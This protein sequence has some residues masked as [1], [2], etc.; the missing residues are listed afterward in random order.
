MFEHL[1]CNRSSVLER[2]RR[3]H[4]LCFWQPTCWKRLAVTRSPQIAVQFHFESRVCLV[5]HALCAC[6]YFT[7]CVSVAK[8]RNR[9]PDRD[10]ISHLKR[11]QKAAG[12]PLPAVSWLDSER[13]LRIQYGSPISRNCSL[14][15]IHGSRSIR[16][17]VLGLAES[18]P[19][20]RAC[21]HDSQVQPDPEAERTLLLMKT[22]P[23]NHQNTVTALKPDPLSMDGM[24]IV[25][26]AS[27]ARSRQ[28]PG[29]NAC[30]QS[31]FLGQIDNTLLI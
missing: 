19:I 29:F 15:D 8:G 12:I 28:G 27:P 20:L 7:L 18:Q 5:I 24:I 26:G 30:C 13:R 9:L 6:P 4:R 14:Q 25:T 23:R 31:N 1:L 10:D 3:Y 17:V 16:D 11:K 2:S 21:F 22:L